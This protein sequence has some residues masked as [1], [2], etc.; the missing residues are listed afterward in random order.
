MYLL[1]IMMVH[2]NCSSGFGFWEN[3][4]LLLTL[5]PFPFTTIDQDDFYAIISPAIISASTAS[6]KPYTPAAP[7][8]PPRILLL[9]A[10][11]LFLV[12]DLLWE[13]L[14]VQLG[15]PAKESWQAG[16]APLS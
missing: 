6:Y 16:G 11:K 13:A 5:L 2:P 14:Q 3:D 10:T 12:F 4:I 7:D 8:V 9:L 1:D 15:C